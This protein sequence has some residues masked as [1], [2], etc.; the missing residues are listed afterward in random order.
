MIKILKVKFNFL[1]FSYADF[2]FRAVQIRL[3]LTDNLNFPNLPVTLIALENATNSLSE[4]WDAY[5]DKPSLKGEVE[6]KR[7]IVSNMLVHI[8]LYVQSC[9][10]QA[11]INT[12]GYELY[13]PKT[14]VGN[15]SVDNLKAK[16]SGM[17][18]VGTVFLQW[19]KSTHRMR[20]CT[21]QHTTGVA[22]AQSVWGEILSTT[23]SKCQVTVGSGTHS[24]RVLPLSTTGMNEPCKPV[25]IVVG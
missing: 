15:V 14:P 21:V 4:T 6:Q 22:T 13:A 2:L 25:T 23:K 12:S 1:R 5:M 11:K 18:G 8:G 16:T 9:N 20:S 7:E 3:M 24:F 17:P 19:K 10:N